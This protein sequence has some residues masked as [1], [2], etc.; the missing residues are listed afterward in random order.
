MPALT[1]TRLKGNYPVFAAFKLPFR[2]VQRSGHIL[3]RLAMMQWC[4]A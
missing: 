2:T 3:N 1:L 4:P